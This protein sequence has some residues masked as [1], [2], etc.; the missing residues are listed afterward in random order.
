[1]DATFLARL[2][3]AFTIGFHYIFPP[4]NIGM[5]LVL[6][7]M[8]GAY[9]RTRN[10][11][12]QQATKFWVRI[13]SL[14]FAIGVATGIVMEFQFGTNWSA[15]SRF[16]GDVFGSALAAEG[17]FAFFLESGFLGLLLFGWDKVGP[18][19]H[20]VSTVAVAFGAHFSAIWITVANS[21]MQTPAGFHLVGEGLARRAETTSFWQVVFNPSALDRLAHTIVGAWQAA[22]FFVLSVAAF[23]LLRNRHRDFAVVSMKVGL[24]VAVVASLG[25]LLTG[26][27]S[28]IVV[29]EHQPAKL[30]AME[31][32]YADNAPAG[33]H[34]FGWVDE[35]SRQVIGL[36]IPGLLSW[37][38]Y[39]DSAHP[40]RGLDA[41]PPEDLPPVNATFQAFH[42]MVG[43]GMFLILLSLV[44][45]L[46][47]R[48]GRLYQARWLL[49]IFVFA[50]VLPQLAN[51]LGWATAEIGRQPWI[52]YGLMRVQQAASPSV[53]AGEVLTSLLLFGVIYLLLFALFVYLL[54]RKIR[55]GPLAEDLET[56]VHRA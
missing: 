15:Y 52:V 1:M 53:A 33:L 24:L 42:L 31:G 3:F 45:A 29:A 41:F 50:V 39:G 23:Y 56:D 27:R 19:M 26:H 48:G 44:G 9:L 49:W 51:Q 14:V 32:V 2:Q 54:D 43:I 38:A 40:V 21:W 28:A 5:G 35:D 16:V 36:E 30:A 8:E 17:I 25:S 6:V 55:K 4:I 47:L 37:L 18:T 10:P 22:A 7:L 46:L 13:F 34:L 20:F 11:V 12:W